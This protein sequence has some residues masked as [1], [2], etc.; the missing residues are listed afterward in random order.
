MRWRWTLPLNIVADFGVTAA[1][2]DDPRSPSEPSRLISSPQKASHEVHLE[3]N[4]EFG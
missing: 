4:N 2:G 3:G 1:E